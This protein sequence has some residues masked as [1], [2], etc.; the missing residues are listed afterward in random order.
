[1]NNKSI[2]IIIVVALFAAGGIFVLSRGSTSSPRVT[3][4]NIEDTPQ[5]ENNIV[6]SP[7]GF[8][9]KTIT[10]AQGTTVTFVNSSNRPFWPATNVHPTHTKYPGSDISKCS[11]Q[12]GTFFDACED[13]DPGKS[14]S[15]TFS[16]VGEW[17]FHDHLN[18]T[19]TGTVVVK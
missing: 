13:I 11:T 6:Y 4:V 18:P 16:E 9:P 15:F 12:K 5:A 19:A 10:V 8:S 17:G 1:M 2:I 7:Q 3:D 14:Y